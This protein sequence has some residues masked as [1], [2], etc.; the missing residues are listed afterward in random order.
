MFFE[1]GGKLSNKRYTGEIKTEA[2]KQVTER[3]YP[4]TEVSQWLGVSTHSLYAGLRDHDINFHP[5]S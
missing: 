4:V 1:T 2:V 3:G 5:A